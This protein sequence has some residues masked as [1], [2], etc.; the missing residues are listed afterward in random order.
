MQATQVSFDLRKLLV[1]RTYHIKKLL[2]S[3]R[4]LA[5]GYQSSKVG[6]RELVCV[7]SRPNPMAEEGL[8]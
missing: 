2:V 4:H 3:A 8:R 5:G 6:G 1:N 7:G